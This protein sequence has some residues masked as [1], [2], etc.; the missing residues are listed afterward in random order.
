M[1]EIIDI[2]NAFDKARDE[3]KNTA[4]ATVV[5][6]EGSSYRKEG[7]RMLITE[8]GELTGAISGGCLEGDALRKALFVMQE[9]KAKLVVYDTSNE[10]DVEVGYQLGCNGIIQVL[11]EPINNDDLI[12]PISLLKEAIANRGKAI[13]VTVFSLKNNSSQKGT[14][15]L[16]KES[17]II[18]ETIHD[19]S[20]LDKL[21]VD[22]NTALQNNQSSIRK[23]VYDDNELTAFI[24]IL[25]PQVTLVLIGAGNDAM[26]LVKMG[27]VIGWKVVVVDGRANYANKKR[28]S[29]GCQVMVSKAEEIFSSIEIDEQTMFVLMTHNYNYDLAV[30][31]QLVLLNARYIG[32]LG[33]RNKLNRMIEE[34]SAEGIDANKE[35]TN[36]YSPVGLDIGAETPEE[37]ALSIMAEIQAIL[38]GKSGNHLGSQGSRNFTDAQ[39]IT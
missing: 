15:L 30:L 26:P 32:I 9:K 35:L 8:D 21:T 31:R 6:V 2:I 5:H 1:K 25:K 20:L 13:I 34:L 16:L 27:E 38:S 11:I 4:L 22:V 28:F 37:I 39:K 14:C 18:M 17:G 10:D 29:S 12:S 3:G 24:N 33:S 7:A 36:V 19:K 23:Y